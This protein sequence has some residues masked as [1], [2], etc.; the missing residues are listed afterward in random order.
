MKRLWACLLAVLLLAGC[1]AERT[2]PPAGEYTMPESGIG[3]REPVGEFTLTTEWESY[4]PSVNQVWFLL[5]NEGDEDAEVGTEYALETL[6]DNGTWYQVPFVENAAWNAMALVIPAGKMVAFSCGFSMFDYDFS[7]GGTYRI[8]KNGAVGEFTLKEGSAV[9]AERPCGFEPLED[10]PDDYGAANAAEG[11]VIYT[12]DGVKNGEAVEAFLN[13]VCLGVPCQL[14][15]VRDCSEG[16]P[17]II[18]VM[19]QNDQFLWRMRNNGEIAEQRF[20]Y[21]VT[22]GRDLYLSNGADW[23]TAERYAG[24]ELACLAPEGTATPGAVG[25]VEQMTAERLAGNVARYRVWSA[26]GEWGAALTDVPTAFSVSWR[27]PGEGSG[28]HLYDLRDWDGLET[29][30]LGLEWREDGA[31]LLICG[32]AGGGTA[33]LLFDPEAEVLTEVPGSRLSVEEPG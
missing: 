4:D 29:A 11:D 22:D 24:K 28:G 32:T 2:D 21:I 1:G 8:V 18:D 12:S 26:D 25:A 9:S 5:T 3:Q 30:I 31:L 17:M 13:K 16:T 19:F 23:V 15:T 10:L 33:S 6:G 20:S 27:K 14:R 7:G